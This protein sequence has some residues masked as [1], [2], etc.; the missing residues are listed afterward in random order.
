MSTIRLAGVVR[1]SIVDGP[2]F[3]FVVFVQGCPH[4]C[5]G[6]HNPQ[7][8]D[9]SGGYVSDTETL[10]AE[11]K[12]NPLLSGVT[13]SGGEPFCQPEPLAE[14]GKEIKKLGLNVITYS[15]Y[16][17]EELTAKQDKNINAL[18]DVCDYLIDGKFILE[19][20]NLMLRFRGSNNQRIVDLS[21]TRQQNHVVT[22]EL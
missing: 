12:K 16:T 20:R 15:G 14:L 7:T 6:C 1:E 19:E 2:G 4:H 11:I 18:L 17:Y 10:L 5:R 22:V 13:L 8:H 9:F 3:R 21:Q